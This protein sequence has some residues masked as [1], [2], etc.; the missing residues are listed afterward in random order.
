LNG[1]A[2][3]FSNTKEDNETKPYL[4][5]SISALNRFSSVETFKSNATLSSVLLTSC[6]TNRYPNPPS[7]QEYA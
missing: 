4:I 7:P 6:K 2:K 5:N 3:D 1:F